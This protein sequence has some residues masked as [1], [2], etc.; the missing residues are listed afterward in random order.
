MLNI[1]LFLGIL[2]SF[3]GI[4]GGPINIH[5]EKT[6]LSIEIKKGNLIE[7]FTFSIKLPFFIAHL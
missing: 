1:G 6:S 4:G 5:F 3:L 7:I 2:S